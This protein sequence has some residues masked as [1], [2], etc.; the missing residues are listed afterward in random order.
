[1]ITF[2]GSYF[3]WHY[4]RAYHEAFGLWVNALRFVLRFFNIPL[5]VRTLFTRFYRLGEEYAPQGF[6]IGDRLS[7]LLINTIMRMV[8]AVIRLVVIGL[9]LC[10]LCVVCAGGVVFFIAWT[11]Y[12]L[13]VLALGIF[14]FIGFV[15]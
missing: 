8:G 2:V 11:V 15:V 1:M 10:V 14:G 12:P 9:G 4:G 3:S 7:A 13:L 5:H 6:D